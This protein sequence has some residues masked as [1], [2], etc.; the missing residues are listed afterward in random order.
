MGTRVETQAQIEALLER[1]DVP[2][3]LDTGHLAAAGVD[4]VAAYRDWRDRID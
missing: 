2:L 3:L 1:V 4:P